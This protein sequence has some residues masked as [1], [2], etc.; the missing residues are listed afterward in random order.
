MPRLRPDREEIGDTL[1]ITYEHSNQG[2]DLDRW[3]DLAAAVRGRVSGANVRLRREF[4]RGLEL[5][6][7]LQVPSGELS[8]VV[9]MIL[10]TVT[11]TIESDGLT[12]PNLLPA[13]VRRTA[14]QL[15]PLSVPR[16]DPVSALPPNPMLVSILLQLA[17][18]QRE[19]L[20]MVYVLHGAGDRA[21]CELK[22][23][24]INELTSIKTSVRERFQGISASSE[25]TVMSAGRDIS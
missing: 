13:L 11:R 7:C 2:A 4:E 12:S 17:P 19:A 5:V 25:S 15:I 10:A 22:G 16:I 6:L 24:T 21:V 3:K 20:E 18:N 1:M 23:L 9:Q 14:R 8:G